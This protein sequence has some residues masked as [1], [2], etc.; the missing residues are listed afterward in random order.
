MR[1]DRTITQY[2]VSITSSMSVFSGKHGRPL[3]AADAETPSAS[4]CPDCPIS[5]YILRYFLAP[6]DPL[7]KYAHLRTGITAPASLTGFVKL[8]E[9]EKFYY[10]VDDKYYEVSSPIIL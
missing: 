4:G 7:P 3:G 8:K 5:T 10:W 6:Q 2:S 1:L 9:F